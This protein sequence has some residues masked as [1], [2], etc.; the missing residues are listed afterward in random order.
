MSTEC[1]KKNMKMSTESLLYNNA[2]EQDIIFFIIKF[3]AKSR[4]DVPTD[5]LE[6]FSTCNF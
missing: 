6:P 3:G 5:G 1:L 2:N 4:L